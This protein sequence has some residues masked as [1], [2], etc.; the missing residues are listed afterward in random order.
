M[1]E[2]PKPTAASQSV[3]NS[4]QPLV[5][6]TA[7]DWVVPGSVI[8]DSICG[9]GIKSSFTSVQVLKSDEIGSVVREGRM[10][11]PIEVCNDSDEGELSC[12]LAL[13]NSDNYS[14]DGMNE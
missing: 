9:S 4:S 7:S 2:K 8:G 5:L 11:N 3:T 6:A 1:S 13:A 10:E 12:H 14:V